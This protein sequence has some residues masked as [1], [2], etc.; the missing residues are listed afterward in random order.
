MYHSQKL[1]SFKKQS[2]APTIIKGQLNI[3]MID[4]CMGRGIIIIMR[5]N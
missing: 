3:V 4:T 2:T 1:V 5:K